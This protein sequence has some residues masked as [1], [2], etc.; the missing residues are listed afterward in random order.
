MFDEKK[1]Q[2]ETK[3]QELRELWKQQPAKREIIELQAR[4]LK[5]ALLKLGKTDLVAEAKKLF[6]V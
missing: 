2:I 3:L 1:K 6:N 5:M 4:A